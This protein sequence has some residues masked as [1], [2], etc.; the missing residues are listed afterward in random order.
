MSSYMV[1]DECLATVV[2]ALLEQ[3][4]YELWDVLG[5][6]STLARVWACPEGAP[7]RDEAE[8]RRALGR[9]LRSMNDRGVQARYGDQEERYWDGE[10]W[11]E[12][13]PPAGFFDLPASVRSLQSAA[14]RPR[15]TIG[16]QA[17]KCVDC[18]L[19]QCAEGAVPQS[20][21]YRAIDAWRDHCAG[22]LARSTQIYNAAGWGRSS[23]TG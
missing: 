6:P 9:A 13:A 20:D 21:L 5:L 18:Y 7:D 15:D 10:G 4:P 14:D 12:G 23:C 22:R 1:S 16:W 8:L 11:V 3:R 17:L 19:Y 2:D